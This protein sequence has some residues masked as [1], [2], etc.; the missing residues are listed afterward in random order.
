MK[1]RGWGYST[2]I[3]KRKKDQV[4]SPGFY[5]VVPAGTFQ[6]VSEHD[7]ETQYSF[8]FTIFREF[9]EELFDMEKSDRAYR[10]SDP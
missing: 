6:P 8:E 5:H 9:L 3:H 10:E 7:I 4:E 1:R 2:F